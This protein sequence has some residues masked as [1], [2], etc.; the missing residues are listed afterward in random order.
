MSKETT[1]QM[2]MRHLT[3]DNYLHLLS[4]RKYPFLLDSL[5]KPQRRLIKPLNHFIYKIDMEIETACN[6]QLLKLNKDA[7]TPW[8]WKIIIIEAGTGNERRGSFGSE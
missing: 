7:L 8:Q 6:L 5:S 3:C 1:P 4:R 2:S